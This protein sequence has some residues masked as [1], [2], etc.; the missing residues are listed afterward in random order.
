MITIGAIGWKSDNFG[1]MAAS[2]P[3]PTGGVSPGGSS[4]GDDMDIQREAQVS[5]QHTDLAGLLQ[6]HFAVMIAE[7]EKRHAAFSKQVTQS[8]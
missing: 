1:K 8:I 5:S 6:N 7:Q 3:E 4:T 2:H